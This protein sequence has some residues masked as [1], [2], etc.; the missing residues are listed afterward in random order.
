MM[1]EEAMDKVLASGFSLIVLKNYVTSI[2][3]TRYTDVYGQSPVYVSKEGFSV[4]ICYG[5][6]IRSVSY[7]CKYIYAFLF[8]IKK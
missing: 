8:Y 6:G 3:N 4:V 2:I 5:W 7:I 1:L